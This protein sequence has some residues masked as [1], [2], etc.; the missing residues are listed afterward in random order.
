MSN[1]ALP[2]FKLYPSDAELDEN[3]RAM[4]DSELGFYWRCLNHSWVN[5]G[6]PADPETRARVLRCEKSYAD[7]QWQ[8][9]GKCFGPMKGNPDRLV[10]PRQ[11]KDRPDKNPKKSVRFLAAGRRPR[12][13]TRKP[14]RIPGMEKCRKGG[15]G[16]DQ[17]QERRADKKPKSPM[18]R[19]ES[20]STISPNPKEKRPA[21]AGDKRGSEYPHRARNAPPKRPLTASNVT[22]HRNARRQGHRPEE[23]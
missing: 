6:L 18:V 13:E 4:D 21:S 17:D 9:V 5:H 20:E 10:N 8:R 2:Y 19:I 3:F 12:F 15:K 22:N 16:D 11:E 23:M 14:E 1:K 7:I